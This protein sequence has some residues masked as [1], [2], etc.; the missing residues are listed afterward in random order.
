MRIARFGIVVLAFAMGWSTFLAWRLLH[1]PAVSI[2]RP[3]PRPANLDSVKSDLCRLGHT[4][5]RY[6]SA[7]GHYAGP[8]ELPSDGDFAMPRER[9]PY[10][11]QI[12][13]P[14]IPDRFVVAAI[15]VRSVD[16]R[17]TVLTLDHS[18]N[19]CILSPNM[20]NAVWR[21]DAPPQT[22]SEVNPDYDCEPCPPA[23]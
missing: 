19:V 11:Y 17:L 12:Y 8:Y 9:W 18:L 21:L 5:R 10:F 20:P 23:R 2:I 6:Y 15:P 7:T 4:E 22:L 16:R 13:V 3:E 14:R 1:P